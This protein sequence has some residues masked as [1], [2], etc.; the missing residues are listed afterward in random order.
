MGRGGHCPHLCHP[1]MQE[2]VSPGRRYW[3]GSETGKERQRQRQ[4]DTTRGR[5]TERQKKHQEAQIDTTW[6]L[7]WTPGPSKQ[8]FVLSQLP[9]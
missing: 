2:E 4:K 9:W 5:Q 7:C 3:S 6:P 8:S 1:E